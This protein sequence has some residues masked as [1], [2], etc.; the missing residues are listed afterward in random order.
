M[1]RKYYLRNF[2]KKEYF[3]IQIYTFILTLNFEGQHSNGASQ[4]SSSAASG[5]GHHAHS[6]KHTVPAH[7]RAQQR[8]QSHPYARPQGT[9]FV[10]P[11]G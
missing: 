7:T 6:G 1:P 11:T 4:G 10:Q 3:S 8:H 5:S 2:P 9:F